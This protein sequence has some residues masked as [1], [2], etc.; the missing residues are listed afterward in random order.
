MA[1]TPDVPT[2]PALEATESPY[3]FFSYAHENWD[4]AV[5]LVEELKLRGFQVFRDVERMREGRPMEH[6][7]GDGIEAADLLMCLLTAASLASVPVVENE[8]KPALRKTTR[9]G[10]PVVM[11]VVCGLGATHEEVTKST[12]PVLQHDFGATWSGAILPKA[13]DPLG[14]DDAAA[15][16]GKA[17]AAV[18]PPARGPD[19]G[20]WRLQLVTRGSASAFD[21]LSVHATSFLGG[22][23][24]Q[25][26]HPAA[27]E[28]LHRGLA[29]LERVL[30][31]HGE[32]HEIELT[33]AAHLTAGFVA[34]FLFR[35][36][37]GW[38]ISVNADDG[39]LY[40]LT[41]ASAHEQLIVSPEP[42]SPDSTF[43]T[44]EINLLGRSMDG[45]VD[46]VLA[47]LGPPSARLRVEHAGGAEYI[48]CSELAA[49]ASATAA[50]I[51]RI[52]SERRAETLH[53]FLAA[54]FAFATFLGA[55]LNAIGG[56]IQLYE[57]AAHAYHPSLEL[58]SR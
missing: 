37:T 11:P 19:S 55:E 43:I 36:P 25:V 16:A 1:Q 15:M 31:A 49:M 50:A 22:E 17:I 8:L 9:E 20:A 58:E 13:T 10:R 26:G 32:R 30:R 56:F 41:A 7:M 42:G 28:R 3:A 46:D 29:D 54:P 6:E 53:L 47:S 2:S 45:L 52:V 5:R 44:A 51:K 24:P 39:Q 48:P 4:S 23:S 40:S 38:L 18:Y 35:R 14:F 21:G 34:G 33:G 57:W 12:W 27:W